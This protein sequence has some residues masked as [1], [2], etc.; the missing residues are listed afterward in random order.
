MNESRARVELYK[1]YTGPA[2]IHLVCI[3]LYV[4]GIPQKNSSPSL[5]VGGVVGGVFEGVV[6][7]LVRG[8]VGGVVGGMAPKNSSPSLMDCSFV[9]HPT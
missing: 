9:L 8:V 5:M 3:K 4:Q 1:I 7:S 6:G 2:F